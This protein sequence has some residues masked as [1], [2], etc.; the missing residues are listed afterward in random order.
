MFS[1]SEAL[2]FA[3]AVIFLTGLRISIVRYFGEK[4]ELGTVKI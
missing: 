3:K 4:A 1:L 2:V